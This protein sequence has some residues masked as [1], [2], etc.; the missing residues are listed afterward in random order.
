MAS[1]PTLWRE[2]GDAS[3]PFVVCAMFTPGYEAKAQRLASSLNG[4][5]L[6][7]AIFQVPQIHRSISASGGDNLAFSKPRF[8]RSALEGAGKPVLY[9]DADVI[10][11]KRPDAVAALCAE[12]CD[13]AIY[14]W[15]ADA[16][17]DAWRPE[18]GT[19][20]WKFFFSVDVASDTQLMA[21]GAV[22]FWKRTDAAL[23]L[24]K[25]WE[26]SLSQHPRSEDDHCLDFAYNHGDR[27]GLTP[28]W[29]PK[30]YA[31]YAFWIYAD[32]V[33]D[34]PEFPAPVTGAFE[35]LGSARF[36]REKIARASK[37]LPFPRDAVVDAQ[38]LQ[39][40]KQKPGGGFA[41]TGPLSLPLFLPKPD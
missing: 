16:M 12:G 20:L 4:F 34:H 17:N 11:R 5:G 31:R 30:E 8:I 10:F 1:P 36:V 27:A 24:L 41:P 18:P 26:Q 37:H 15:L 21:S 22:Q 33:I 23:T 2:G 38:A 25:D 7:H 35:S 28:A 40:L 3:A 9:V 39:L 6:A 32:P 13:F 29:L 19:P 14:N